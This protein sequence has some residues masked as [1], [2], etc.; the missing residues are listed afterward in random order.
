MAKKAVKPTHISIAFKRDEVAWLAWVMRDVM[1]IFE[2]LP[3]GKL[4]GDK[5]IE[6][7]TL[8]NLTEEVINERAKVRKVDTRKRKTA[9]TGRKGARR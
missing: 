4:V 5:I 7:E 9:G 2:V 1:G 6:A 3:V 8:F